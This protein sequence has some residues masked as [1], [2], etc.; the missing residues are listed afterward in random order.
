MWPIRFIHT[1]SLGRKLEKEYSARTALY[2]EY[3][4]DKYG[5]YFSLSTFLGYVASILISGFP[6]LSRTFLP[7]LRV[8]FG[9]NFRLLGPPSF[10]ER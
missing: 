7:T 2:A 5:L 10:S 3:I 1:H 9:S 6:R 4:A 8:D